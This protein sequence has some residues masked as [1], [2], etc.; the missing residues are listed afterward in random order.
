MIIILNNIVLAIIIGLFLGVIVPLMIYAFYLIGINRKFRMSAYSSMS[1]NSFFKTVLNAGNNGEFLTF[2]VLESIPVYK[3]ILA[4]VYIPKKNGGTSEIDILMI[5]ENGILV[6]ES[7][8][9]SGWIFGDENSAMWTQS[10]K[11]GFKSRFYNP[12][13]QNN[14]HVSALFDYLGDVP[15]EA[16]KSYVVFSERCELKKINVDQ[17]K[18]KLIKRNHLFD[19]VKAE[20]M[21]SDFC[22]SREQVDEIYNRIVVHTAI[23]SRGKVLSGLLENQIR[24]DLGLCGSGQEMSFYRSI[25][26]NT[27]IYF[28]ID[29]KAMLKIKGLKDSKLQRVFDL[30]EDF[31]KESAGSKGRNFS[32]LYDKLTSAEHG[33]RIK[34]GIIPFFIANSKINALEKLTIENSN[35]NKEMYGELYR[36]NVTLQVMGWIVIGA[37]TISIILQLVLS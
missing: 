35:K 8:N 31:I 16:L 17:T 13:K 27:G 33:F 11:G 19:A 37:L 22:L 29:G 2:Q 20:V 10:L 5:T 18:V 24:K 36:K 25:I 9:F 4:N 21:Y 7:K 6:F 32:E 23:N 28:E 1:G 26:K 12:I 15:N 3:K 34:K 30:I 14:S